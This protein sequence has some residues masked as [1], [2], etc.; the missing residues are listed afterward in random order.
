MTT[1]ADITAQFTLLMGGAIS[2]DMPDAKL[3]YPEELRIL[4]WN[5][6]QQYFAVTHTAMLKN[7]A[8]TPETDGDG[9]SVSL[10]ADWIQ[11]AGVRVKTDRLP[12]TDP[13]TFPILP[14]R[15]GGVT[16]DIWLRPTQLIP[17]EYEDNTGYV[18]LLDKLYF[19]DTRVN[20]CILWYYAHYP[21]VVDDLSQIVVPAWAEWAIQNLAISNL[22]IPPSVGVA[23]LRRF[24]TKRDAGSPEDN[25]SRVQAIYHRK[26]YDDIVGK[27]A[28]P[29]RTL[30]YDSRR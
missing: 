5:R 19:P 24:Q 23:D 7:T 1:W 12:A 10:P 27:Q 29:P 17:G 14:V 21:D 28:A 13:I 20:N 30:F 11:I 4:A 15:G 2:T 26:I 16:R 25:P 18:L 3:T 6:A 9:V 22:L 8:L